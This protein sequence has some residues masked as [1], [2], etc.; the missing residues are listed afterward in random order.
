MN[1]QETVEKEIEESN[2]FKKFFEYIS[3]CV[4]YYLNECY[5]AN[6]SMCDFTTNL[7]CLYVQ[8]LLNGIVENLQEY[9]RFGRHIY[10]F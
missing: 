10:I 9:C 2:C 5:S 6:C 3:L 4:N 1:Y 8:D 7:Q